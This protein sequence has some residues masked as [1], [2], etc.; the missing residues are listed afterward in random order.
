MNLI[1]E[2]KSFGGGHLNK[3]FLSQK[4]FKCPFGLIENLFWLLIK[5]YRQAMQTVQVRQ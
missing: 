5:K 1:L 2:Y 3:T 4:L